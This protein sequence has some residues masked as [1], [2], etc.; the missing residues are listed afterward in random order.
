MEDKD[1]IKALE[2]CTTTGLSC[3]DCPAFVKV[4]RSNCKKYFRGAIDLINRQQAEIE[5]LKNLTSEKCC[6]NCI[7]EEKSLQASPCCECFGYMNFAPKN[8][9]KLIKAKAYIEFLNKFIS[10]LDNP[11]IQ[12]A[13][14]EYVD[15]I[16][17]IADNTCK[18]LVGE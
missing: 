16:K 14:K 2:C 17:A 6:D 10:Q 7:H 4:D 15:F 11:Y 9:L 18:E 12:R 5:R 1:I 13:G 3:K 8:L